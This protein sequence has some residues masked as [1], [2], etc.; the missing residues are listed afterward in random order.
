MNIFAKFIIK[1]RVSYHFTR[2]S[3]AGLGILKEA[4]V[5]FFF[6]LLI[7]RL[8]CWANMSF[9]FGCY[10]YERGRGKTK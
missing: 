7:S 4:E 9:S 6:M 8:S 5:F 3:I 2:R 10:V 1:F